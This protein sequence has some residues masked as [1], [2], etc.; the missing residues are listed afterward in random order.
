MQ[1][2]TKDIYTVG[3]LKKKSEGTNLISLQYQ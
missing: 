1:N 3:V 2:V